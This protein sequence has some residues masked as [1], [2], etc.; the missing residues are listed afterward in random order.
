MGTQQDASVISKIKCREP[1][2]CYT[3]SSLPRFLALHTHQN[4]VAWDEFMHEL[5]YLIMKDVSIDFGARY[6]AEMTTYVDVL[7]LYPMLDT[8]LPS[9]LAIGRPQ[10][11]LQHWKHV[12]FVAV[13]HND[14]S[15]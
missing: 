4:M 6:A 5:Y 2:V 7:G 9:R 12:P 8:E 10:C 3:R 13:R 15:A 14:Y 1:Y 11:P